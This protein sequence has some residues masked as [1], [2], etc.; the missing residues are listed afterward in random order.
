[1]LKSISRLRRPGA[2]ALL[3]SALVLGAGA[4]G[5]DDGGDSDGAQPSGGVASAGPVLERDADPGDIS[6][7]H[8][9]NRDNFPATHDVAFQLAKSLEGVTGSTEQVAVRL[10]GAMTDLCGKRD[11]PDYRPAKDAAAAV[12]RG[13]YETRISIP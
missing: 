10:T 12:E 11:D 7:S 1:M 13:E 9:A 5:D 2:V 4:C 3:G 8:L 6:C